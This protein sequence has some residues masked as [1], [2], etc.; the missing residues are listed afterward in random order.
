ML[1]SYPPPPSVLRWSI[2]FP[3]VVS[4]YH[5]VMVTYK[6]SGDLCR[7]VRIYGTGVLPTLSI[8]HTCMVLRSSDFGWSIGTSPV[9]TCSWTTVARSNGS[10][11]TGVIGS[12]PPC[13]T[14]RCCLFR[15]T[16]ITATHLPTQQTALILSL[17]HSSSA[18][19]NRSKEYHPRVCLLISV[20][21]VQ[22]LF[23]CVDVLNA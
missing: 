5:I 1:A 2:T 13:A 16:T 11:A 9:T 19:N 15:P 20:V 12:T 23:V 3:I 14:S 18:R 10:T 7:N 21:R 22:L 8:A 4:A 17:C 6:I